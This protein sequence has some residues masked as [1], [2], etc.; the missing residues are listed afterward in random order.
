MKQSYNRPRFDDIS[1]ETIKQALQMSDAFFSDN[2]IEQEPKTLFRLMLEDIL[3]AYQKQSDSAPFEMI[4]ARSWHKVTVIILIK[5]DSFNVL[6]A[7]KSSF[8]K[9]QLNNPVVRPIWK[10]ALGKN[11]IKCE[12]PVK[13]MDLLALKQ[14]LKYMASE[15]LPFRLGVALRSLNAMVMLLE[16]WLAARIIEG[17]TSSDFKKIL[18]NAVLVLLMEVL[19]SLLTY[20]ST[21]LLE[22][23]YHI[24]VYKLRTDITENILRIKTENIDACGTGIFTERIISGTYD[25]VNGIHELVLI[26]TEL[27]RFIS[28]MAA[29]GSVSLFMMFFELI[30]FIAYFLIVRVQAKKTAGDSRRVAAASERFSGLVG[31]TIRANRDIKLLHCEDSFLIKAKDGIR[32]LNDRSLERRK[33]NNIH[34]LVRSQFVAWTTLAYMIVLAVMMAKY[35]LI[36]ASALILYNYNGKVYASA[37]SVAG[38]ADT[39]Y[40]LLQA[41]ERLYQL[42]ESDDFSRETFGKKN[43]ESVRGDIELKDVFFSYTHQDMKPVPV[44]KDLSL[45]I[46]AGQSV[47]LVGNSGCGK[48]TVFSLISRL[49]EPDRGHILLDGTDESELDRDTIRNNIG[50]VSQSPYLFNM[51]IR[52]NFR[53]IKSDVTEEEIIQACKTACIHDEIGNLPDGYDTIAGEGGCMLSGGQRQRIAL[54]RALLKDYPVI[55]LDEATSALDN[56]TQSTICDAIHNMHGRSTVIMIAHRLSTVINCE[57]LFFIENGRVLASGTHEELMR[58]CEEYRRM[59]SEEC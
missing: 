45:R 4:L 3:L 11:I 13:K 44:L 47:A 12:I 29:F 48:S 17:I 49:Y 7:Y 43:M 23:S 50:T 27:L 28:L 6:E 46:P 26:F 24:M 53:L 18:I 30:L 22:R 9:H 15:K 54:A 51:S 10:Y 59:Y 39:I 56:E 14:I 37:Q 33:R 38:F 32:N 2:S 8:T 25:I 52:D 1:A 40:A 31:E 42:L 58:N 35:G 5:S 19:S 20:F 41:S 16:P 57:Q 21:N 55:M 36:A 34:T